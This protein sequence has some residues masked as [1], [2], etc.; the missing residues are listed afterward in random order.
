[1]LIESTM[2]FNDPHIK[3]ITRNRKNDTQFQCECNESVAVRDVRKK[4]RKRFH[5]NL[6]AFYRLNSENAK[7]MMQW[8]NAATFAD[9]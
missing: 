3:R 2:E 5:N 7:Q 1:M 4:T 6:R 9:M 8:N